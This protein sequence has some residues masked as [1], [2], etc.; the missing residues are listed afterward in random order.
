MNSKKTTVTYQSM[1]VRSSILLVNL[2]LIIIYIHIYSYRPITFNNGFVW[3]TIGIGCSYVTI[4]ITINFANKVT[5]LLFISDVDFK[6][7]VNVIFDF[8]EKTPRVR[9]DHLSRDNQ[10]VGDGPGKVLTSSRRFIK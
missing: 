3:Y 1:N 8:G 10:P 2:L 9:I 5:Q 6:C 4:L 7:C